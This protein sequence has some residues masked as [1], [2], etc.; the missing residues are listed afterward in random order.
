MVAREAIVRRLAGK[1]F[2][3][4]TVHRFDLKG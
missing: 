2:I 1:L 3:E 4:R